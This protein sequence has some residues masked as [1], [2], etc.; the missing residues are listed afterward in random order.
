MKAAAAFVT[1]M[2]E[3][4]RRARKDLDEGAVTKNYGGN[5]KDAISLLTGES[6]A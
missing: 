2:R 1:D 3:I 5:V 4:R 6:D